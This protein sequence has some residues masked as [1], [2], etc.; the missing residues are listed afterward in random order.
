MHAHLIIKF[1]SWKFLESSQFY[2]NC[3]LYLCT[4]SIV[5]KMIIDLCDSDSDEEYS[6]AVNTNVDSLTHT[7][8]SSSSFQSNSGD[9]LIPIEKILNSESSQIKKPR[10]DANY[11]H[12]MKKGFKFR[13][14]NSNSS[15]NSNI[16]LQ[17]DGFQCHEDEE[18]KSTSASVPEIVTNTIKTKPATTKKPKSKSML[19]KSQSI[20]VEGHVAS[21]LNKNPRNNSTY[22]SE[23]AMVT[24]PS[25]LCHKYLESLL[26]Y[27]TIENSCFTND[28]MSATQTQTEPLN[29]NNVNNNGSG[30]NINIMSRL[31]PADHKANTKKGKKEIEVLQTL[32]DKNKLSSSQDKQLFSLH[33]DT[34][35]SVDARTK[36]DGLC[37]WTHRK[38][39]MGGS[40][41]LGRTN[42]SIFPFVVVFIP[43]KTFIELCLD[44]AITTSTASTSTNQH[45]NDENEFTKLKTE[46]LNL[47]TRLSTLFGSLYSSVPSETDKLQSTSSTSVCRISLVIENL[48]VAAISYLQAGS[49][50]PLQSQNQN[51]P[52]YEVCTAFT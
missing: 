9:D 39:E 27:F 35:A 28:N 14:P 43:P 11:Y 18:T 51:Q 47:R 44:Y 12:K 29:D 17:V 50:V 42:S 25:L 30:N 13:K 10:G 26:Q 7:S 4:N 49:M 20:S 48:H 2:I 37:V 15:S 23:I 6:H 31:L 36:I 45:N 52:I 32:I 33:I 16:S 41:G 40:C 22:Y 21:T 34:S 3:R 19:S 46:M 8:S 5:L 1:I 38:C 24:S